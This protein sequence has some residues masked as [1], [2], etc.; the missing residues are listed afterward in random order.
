MAPLETQHREV[1]IIGA[2]PSGAIAGALLKRQ[3]HDVLIV[4]RQR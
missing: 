1:V 4:E 2:G 3:G